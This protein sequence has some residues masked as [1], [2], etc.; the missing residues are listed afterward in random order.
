MS[1]KRVRV[2]QMSLPISQESVTTIG[3]NAIRMKRQC[4][5]S[6]GDGKANQNLVSRDRADAIAAVDW[7]VG[8][9]GICRTAGPLL[10]RCDACNHKFCHYDCVYGICPDCSRLGTLGDMCEDCDDV[11]SYFTF[12]NGG[13]WPGV[14]NATQDDWMHGILIINPKH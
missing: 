9:C 5:H 11:N 3:A 6:I 13:I 1:T 10:A 8:R 7:S 12:Y 2:P 4:K 14:N